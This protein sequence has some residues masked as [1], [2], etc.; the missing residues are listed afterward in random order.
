MKFSMTNLSCY[1]KTLGNRHTCR[2]KVAKNNVKNN[3][4]CSC[5][6]VLKM[7]LG[8]PVTDFSRLEMVLNLVKY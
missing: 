5:S 1:D 7:M 2:D 4:F 6:M 3:V 8:T